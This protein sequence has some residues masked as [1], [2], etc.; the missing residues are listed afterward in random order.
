MF[1]H[2]YVQYICVCVIN[3]KIVG[4]QNIYLTIVIVAYFEDY[5]LGEDIKI[6]LSMATEWANDKQYTNE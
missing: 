5:P 4:W 3:P 2:V 1:V 6:F